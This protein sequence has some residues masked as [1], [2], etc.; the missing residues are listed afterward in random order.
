MKNF[1]NS[2][3]R[4]NQTAIA[5]YKTMINFLQHPVQLSALLLLCLSLE[6][7]QKEG[8]KENANTDA[9]QAIQGKEG[10]S[11]VINYY[12]GLS[13]QTTM[14][15]QQARAA[16]AKYRN[17]DNAIRDGYADIAVDVQHMGHHYMNASLV[18]G[19]FDIRHPEILV[20]NRDE[21]GKQVL[22]AVEYAVP[23]TDPMPE[24]FTGSADVWN[25][26]SGFPLWLVHAWVWAYNPDGVF[27]WTN[28]SVEL[29]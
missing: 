15:L 9:V 22:V 19:T 12:S 6:A 28:E 17:I 24:G 27:N 13:W 18:D 16:T 1:N 11:E 10:R 20:Y 4:C 2:A 3:W 23:L 8:I 14:E 7:C 25:G 26:T 21:N 29:H 5:L